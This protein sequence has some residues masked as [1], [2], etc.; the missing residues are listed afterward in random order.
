MFPSYRN[1]SVNLLCKSSDC[2]YMMGTLVIK[3]L[4]EINI[5]NRIYYFDGMIN[6]KNLD[7]NKI[8]IDKKSYKN[9][10]IYCI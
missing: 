9:F 6:I 3:G 1:D 10:L 2:F 4:K 8:K 5:K 7:R